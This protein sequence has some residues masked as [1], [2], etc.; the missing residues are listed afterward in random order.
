MKRVLSID[1]TRGLVMIIMAIDHIRDLMHNAS[2]TLNPLDLST[3]TPSIFFT[4]WITHLC[5]PTFVF[6]SGV[7]AYL[8]Y[9]RKNDYKYSRNFLL[10]R[11][12]WLILLEFTVITFAVWWDIHFRFFLFQVI[13]AI[14]FGFIILSF[15]LK[16]NLRTI[17][18]IGLAIIFSHDLVSIIL[19]SHPS[20]MTSVL[21]PLF[22]FSVLFP[23][24]NTT[25]LMGYP[26]IP[27]LGIM[28]TGFGAGKLFETDIKLRKQ[29]FIKLGIASLLLFILLRF[30]NIYGD[31]LPWSV[32]KNYVYS[33]LSF[34]NVSKYPP[35]LQYCLLMLG[36]MF[37]ILFIVEGFNNKLTEILMVYGKVPMFYYLMHWYIIH[38]VMFLILFIEG[39]HR[40]DL[41]PTANSFGR[42]VQPNGVS[43][44]YIY[45]IWMIVVIF[46]YPFCKWYGKYKSAHP[47]NKWLSYL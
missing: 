34:I 43:L 31:P 47:E 23:T 19:S 21:S 41:F 24:K 26:I 28:F 38:P 29:Y 3:T 6:L 14:G 17:L 20:A 44:L 42:P 9:K 18:I 11:G 8:S 37:T 1:I 32:Q 5:A 2:L 16:L 4:R 36:I 30:I 10:S 13:A 33:F 15:L 27:W 40:K 46:L 12:L 7:S 22:N 35:S 25:L 39:F 45:L